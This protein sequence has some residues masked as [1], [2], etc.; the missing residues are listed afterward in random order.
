MSII[1]GG[2]PADQIALSVKQRFI[3]E[4]VCISDAVHFEGHEAVGYT[5]LQ[6][7]F[8]RLLA[9]ERPLVQTHEAVNL[10]FESFS[11]ADGS[12]TRRYGG[13]GLGLSI[14]KRLIHMM[15]GRVWIESELGKGTTVHFT[16]KFGL[17]EA[18]AELPEASP[19][20]L[21]NLQ[22]LV[23]D[24]N[25]T[26]RRILLETTKNWR[27][28]PTPAESG[29]VALG[30]LEERPFDLVL[31]DLQMPGMDGFEVADRIQQRWPRL[32][33]NIIVLSSLGQR[34]DA[35]R[36]RALNVGAYL[37]K[38]VKC[39]DLLESIQGLLRRGKASGDAAAGLVTRHSLRESRGPEPARRALN[40]LVA[41]DNPINQ[42]VWPVACLRRQGTASSWRPTATWLSP[43]SP[44]S[45]LTWSSWMS[46]CP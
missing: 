13:T 6:L 35:D 24:D 9:D 10:I 32:G 30:L 27:M 3:A 12:T 28:V 45:I 46:R 39:S 22:V 20:N 31:L 37:C 8:E 43:R 29:G 17:G 16:A 14:S 26:N 21:A 2:G 19:A 15:K 42:T 34:G 40:I 18:P 25:D 33:V 4:R 5:L 41:E 38:P 1:S 36:C 11:Q 44:S 7:P 23:V